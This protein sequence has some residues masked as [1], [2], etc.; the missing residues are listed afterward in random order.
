MLFANL[1]TEN[2]WTLRLF[3]VIL[4]SLTSYMIWLQWHQQ[5]ILQSKLYG[6][7]SIHPNI[8]KIT[9]KIFWNDYT[10]A[11]L[12]SQRTLI[13]MAAYCSRPTH[14]C[15]NRLRGHCFNRWMASFHGTYFYTV[16]ITAHYI[17]LSKRQPDDWIDLLYS[18]YFAFTYS[19]WQIPR[20]CTGWL[21]WPKWVDAC[22][23][24][25]VSG[26]HHSKSK[27]YMR[28]ATFFTYSLIK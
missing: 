27:S 28:V 12:S 10:C 2:H 9:A 7:D 25:V 21:L 24:H 13:Q 3:K 4:S 23:M 8:H 20:V 16:F 6:G 11:F 5:P 15:R 1:L 14:S 26:R 19:R 18:L 22:K 17:N